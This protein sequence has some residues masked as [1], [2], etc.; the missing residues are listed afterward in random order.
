T[1]TEG[2]PPGGKRCTIYFTVT[3]AGDACTVSAVAPGPAAEPDTV[4][5][6]APDATGSKR[7]AASKP[8]PDA[9]TT[10]ASRTIVRSTRPAA[11]STCSVNCAEMPPCRMKLP[12]WTE[13]TLIT[14]GLKVS[15]T[16]NVDVRGALL[17]EIGTV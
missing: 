1:G 8:L 13:R 17:T 15:V 12:S 11:G 10:S 14:A 5:L 7:T 16:V 9:P 3:L 6:V 2:P 4:M